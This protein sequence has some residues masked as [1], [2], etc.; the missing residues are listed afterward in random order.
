MIRNN[1]FLP[2]WSAMRF[3][4]NLY[5]SDNIKHPGLLKWRLRRHAG[6]LD[7]YVI[8]LCE[9]DEL[10][11]PAP[12]GNQLEFYH[13]AF[14]QQPFYRN[15]E[16]FIIGI[17]RGRSAAIALCARIVQD[18]VT[19]TGRPDVCSYLFPDGCTMEYFTT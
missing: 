11:E 7:V 13:C 9:Y 14:L 4:K 17:A 1:G 16:P 8:T 12:D 3:Y 19:Q 18:A 2:G 10:H 6:S 15:H 5:T